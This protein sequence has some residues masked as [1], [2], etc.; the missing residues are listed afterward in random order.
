MAA[1]IKSVSTIGNP[2]FPQ[3]FSQPGL[4]TPNHQ[5]DVTLIL[6][7]CSN[8]AIEIPRG[9]SLGFNENL[10]NTEFGEI[11]NLSEKLTEEK[12]SKDLP[13]VSITL[14]RFYFMPFPYN[15]CF[16]SVHF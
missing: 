13:V 8:Q 15:G 12:L 11:L 2:D 9:M 7:N 14:F 6:Q 16:L 4:V 5:G 10:R 1:G 3:I